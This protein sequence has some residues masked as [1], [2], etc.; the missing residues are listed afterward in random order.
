MPVDT[1]VYIFERR[2]PRYPL[3]YGKTEYL[4]I[5]VLLNNH[6]IYKNMVVAYTKK[7]YCKNVIE[8]FKIEPIRVTCKEAIDISNVMSMSLIVILA[9]DP[10]TVFLKYNNKTI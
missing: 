10:V 1:K 9:L 3:C 2:D 8:R 7:A 5:P 6:T 4:T